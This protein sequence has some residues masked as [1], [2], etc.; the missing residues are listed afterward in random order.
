MDA[1]REGRRAGLG[2]A[3]RHCIGP[4]A[5]RGSRVCLPCLGAVGQAFVAEISALRSRR[6]SMWEVPPSRSVQALVDAPTGPDN[7]IQL[8][9][10][11]DGHRSEEHTSELQS[12]GHLVCRL[13][14][15]KKNI[16]FKK[17]YIH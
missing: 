10:D 13:L 9:H 12:R 1:R 11:A 7:G 6:H 16:N 4:A 17:T 2:K 15:E 5:D 8:N 3:W 14:L